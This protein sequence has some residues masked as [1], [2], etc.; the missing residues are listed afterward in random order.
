[1]FWRLPKESNL[2]YFLRFYATFGKIKTIKIYKN[3]VENPLDILRTVEIGGVLWVETQ[4][5][6]SLIRDSATL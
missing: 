6:N 1:M 5:K 2:S 4:I 3:K